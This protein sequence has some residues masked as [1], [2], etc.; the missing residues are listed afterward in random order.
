MTYIRNC[1]A[2]YG[3]WHGRRPALN[4]AE[5]APVI[6]VEKANRWR[7]SRATK[8]ML[9]WKRSWMAYWMPF[10]F[11]PI[12]LFRWVRFW[13]VFASVGDAGPTCSLT[14]MP[15]QK[16]PP[17]GNGVFH[18]SRCGWHRNTAL[19]SLRCKG[20]GTDGR[21]TR[22]DIQALIDQP[23]QQ[24]N[25]KALAAPA[26]RKLAHDHHIDLSALQGTGKEGR[27]R[28]EDVEAAAEAQPLPRQ[29]AYRAHPLKLR[30]PTA[31]SVDQPHAA[32]HCPSSQPEC[33][34]KRPIFIPLPSWILP[35]R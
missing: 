30:K 34:R 25:G 26:V 4:L 23:P 22:E 29:R 12:R 2:Q 7:K 10:W 27:I 13:R 24:H 8:P 31:K 15:S 1:S 28:R 17:N 33:Y 35:T 20:R 16:K 14:R 9:N 5:A 32:D 19:T 11:P 6:A 3:L 21:I 18:P